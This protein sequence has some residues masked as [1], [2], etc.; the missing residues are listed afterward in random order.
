MEANLSSVRDS[1]LAPPVPDQGISVLGPTPAPSAA[2]VVTTEWLAGGVP[3]VSVIGE[4]DLATAPTLDETLLT[5]PD[6]AAGAVIVDLASCGFIALT[7]LRVLVAARERL[8][9]S[10]RP[11]VLVCGNPSLLRIFQIIRV[12]GLFEIY[13]SLSAATERYD[14]G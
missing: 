9:R 7:G 12:D 4:L 5:L 13:P 3:V 8:V 10:S 1:G 2:F 14:D 11:L 6:N